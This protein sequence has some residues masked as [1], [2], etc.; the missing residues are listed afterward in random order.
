MWSHG[1]T[2]NDPNNNLTT[3]LSAHFIGPESGFIWDKIFDQVKSC[4]PDFDCDGRVTHMDM[5]KSIGI[6]FS[7]HNA[8]AEKFYDERHVAKNMI[9]HLGEPVFM[10]RRCERR[11]RKKQTRS[12][13]L[14][15][16]TP[17][18]T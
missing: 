10:P 8:R 18:R 14:L 11:P 16:P 7:K 1:G 6:S 5:E 15:A 13:L 2:V 4:I 17:R 9:P 3:M 12:W